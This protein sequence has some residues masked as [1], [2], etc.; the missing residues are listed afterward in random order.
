MMP[1]T[2][3]TYND[4]LDREISDLARLHIGHVQRDASITDPNAEI[5]KLAFGQLPL[6]SSDSENDRVLRV[7]LA[8]LRA[9]LEEKSL[10]AGTLRTRDAKR[11]AFR[12]GFAIEMFVYS[13]T[14]GVVATIVIT[15]S[16]A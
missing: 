9:A 12:R 4:T 8:G 15:T 11:R 5:A 7:Y 10:P 14:A 13:V 3:R 2:G 16:P 6:S 1:A